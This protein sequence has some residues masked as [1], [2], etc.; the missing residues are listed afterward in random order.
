MQKTK[1]TEQQI[2]CGMKECWHSFVGTDDDELF[3]ADMR[4]DLYL[5]E[6]EVWDEFD[7]YQLANAMEGF[8]Q[9]S[10]SENEWKNI[11]GVN[12]PKNS[13][14]E[15]EELVGQ[16]LTFRVLAQFIAERAPA[17]SFQPVTIINRECAP[18]GVFYGIRQV[19]DE[20]SESVYSP[21]RF[22]P[23]TK[24]IDVFRG[25]A[26]EKFWSQLR[27]MTEQSVP[28]IPSSWR[29]VDAWGCLAC[30]MGIFSAILLSILTENSLYL[31]VLSVCAVA[32]WYVT[33]LYKHYSNPLPSELQTFRDL[34]VLIA[35]HDCDAVRKT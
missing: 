3:E 9:F 24:I 14:E 15:W 25:N 28:E 20:F 19:A 23:S 35:E 33:L 4:I 29:D 12:L 30:F 5:K 22:A 16:H 8:F 27:W 17:V 13:A 10:C 32:V 1:Y 21:H 11:F 31:I 6:Y 18:A 7:F 34:A 2:L 26:L